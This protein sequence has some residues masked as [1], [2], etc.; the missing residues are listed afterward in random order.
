MSY[1]S[2]TRSQTHSSAYS[3]WGFKVCTV[4]SSRII[5]N[6]FLVF[7]V[8]VPFKN[9]CFPDSLDLFSKKQMAQNQCG[10]K[11]TLDIDICI[12]I[13][14]VDIVVRREASC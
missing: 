8:L 14:E 5:Q 2:L 3:A 12:S 10:H 7:L 13:V 11:N 9:V 4:K 6:L 1:T